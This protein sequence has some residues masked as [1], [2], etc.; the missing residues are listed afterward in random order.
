MA[1]ATTRR[2]SRV[3]W[4]ASCGNRVGHQ[5][6]DKVRFDVPQ[7]EIILCNSI[8]NLL[9][10]RGQQWQQRRREGRERIRR[11]INLIHGWHEI[12][13]L[14]LLVFA[15]FLYRLGASAVLLFDKRGE[16]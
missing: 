4:S 14:L 8:F 11:W 5:V 10:K 12:R 3:T 1:R 9:G 16:E 6:D 13:K 2:I 15:G 7:N